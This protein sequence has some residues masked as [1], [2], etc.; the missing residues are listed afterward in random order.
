MADPIGI[1]GR[2]RAG[3]FGTSINP[4]QVVLQNQ[5]AQQKR[6]DALMEEERKNRDA[7]VD[8]LRKFNPDKVW[9]PFYD[10]VNQYVQKEIRDPFYQMRMERQPI[11]AIQR[12]MDRK[13]GDANTLV[14]KINW[15]KE[16]HKDAMDTL[17][18][19]DVGKYYKR[20]ETKRA[21]NDVFFNGRV[22]KPSSE[23]NA[24]QIQD[25]FD[26]VD[27]MDLNAV[28]VDFMKTLPDKVNQKYTEYWSKYGQNYDVTETKTKL[29]IQMIPGADGTM[30]AVLDPRTGQPKISMTDEVY[31]QAMENP[32]LSK[33]VEKYVPSGP[34]TS[35]QT[36]MFG[37][38]KSQIQKQKEFLTGLLEGLDPATIQ[39]RP[40]QGFRRPDDE[41]RYNAY[42]RGFRTP[43]A[44]L[45]DRYN[46]A[47]DVTK[48]YRPDRLEQANDPNSDNQVYYG[49]DKGKPIEPGQK[50][51]T[52]VVAHVG[53]PE[54]E[55]DMDQWSAMSTLD[56]VL[57]QEAKG[58]TVKKDIISIATAEGQRKAMLALNNRLDKLD[59]K[60]SIG[61]DEFG[62]F[63]E[64]K[65]QD[66]IKKNKATSSGINWK[67]AP[68]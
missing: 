30:S 66:Q 15:L 59:P 10:E 29:G 12:T 22:A 37:A 46:W 17:D 39:S 35:E 48:N 34:A 21:I 52:I 6:A 47:E 53:V 31:L 40:Q 27:N 32:Y 65:Y 62:N 3:V 56:K 8:D 18:S 19:D 23:I 50:H 57:Y 13:K 42:G 9:E 26:N 24:D 20:N 67:K 43:I 14:A 64:A 41:I 58:R 2:G 4:L 68:K 28:S 51:S 5:A 16:Q 45:E 61:P 60:R 38:Q 55:M 44:D 63:T 54:G 36:E 11:S 1:Q 25:V 49:D 33:A 7:M